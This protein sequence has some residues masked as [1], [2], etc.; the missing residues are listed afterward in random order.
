LI[1]LLTL[2]ATGLSRGLGFR[3]LQGQ[4]SLGG[5]LECGS[6]AAAFQGELYTNTA[7][8][9]APS[10]PCALKNSCRNTKRDHIESQAAALVF[11]KLLRLN[12]RHTQTLY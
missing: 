4:R 8:I 7:K 9:S 10:V 6:P 5:S 1:L 2:V 11:L 12:H 3:I